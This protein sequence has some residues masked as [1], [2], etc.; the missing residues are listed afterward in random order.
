MIENFVVRPL[1]LTKR[2]IAE[3]KSNGEALVLRP[4]L[5]GISEEYHFSY[6]CSLSQEG[7]CFACAQRRRCPFL[8]VAA[9]PINWLLTHERIAVF[10]QG[11]K[12][13]FPLRHYDFN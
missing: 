3:A 9:Q 7:R 11:A 13:L 1:L 5:G 2:S 12:H 6:S 4:P 8:T 10:S